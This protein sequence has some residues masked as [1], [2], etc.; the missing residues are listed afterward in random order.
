MSGNYNFT[1]HFKY[2]QYF[3]KLIKIYGNCNSRFYCGPI[4]MQL[5]YERGS[6]DPCFTPSGWFLKIYFK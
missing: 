5:S 3:N 2:Y 1:V 4:L 6:L